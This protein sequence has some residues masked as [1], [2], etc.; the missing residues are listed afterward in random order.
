MTISKNLAFGPCEWDGLAFLNPWNSPF[1]ILAE[2]WT[3]IFCKFKTKGLW[4]LRHKVDLKAEKT[5]GMCGSLQL[6]L[7]TS[8]CFSPIQLPV[9]W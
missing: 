7:E 5:V 3:L 9:L 4:T 2:G 6:N 8:R 1:L